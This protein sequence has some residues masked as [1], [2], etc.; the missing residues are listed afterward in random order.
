MKLPGCLFFVLSLNVALADGVVTI[1]VPE[2]QQVTL[3]EAFTK[4]WKC[5]RM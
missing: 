2:G 3:E 5:S 1:S 4:C